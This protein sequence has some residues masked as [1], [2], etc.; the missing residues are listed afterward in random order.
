MELSDNNKKMLKDLDEIMVT[1]D[2]K[3]KDWWEEFDRD[4]RK[5]RFAIGEKCMKYEYDDKTEDLMVEALANLCHNQ[6]SGWM[7][8]ML[9]KVLDNPKHTDPQFIET[10]TARWKRQMTTQ[11]SELPETEKES[12]RNEAR[13]ILQ[14]IKECMV[15][16]S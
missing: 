10:W 14:V 12:D 7:K 9:P 8:W 15:E 16:K 3:G 6:W 1:P 13:K 5:Y 11:Y 2:N 4:F